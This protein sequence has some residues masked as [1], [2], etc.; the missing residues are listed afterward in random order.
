MSRDS[1]MLAFSG[2]GF[3]LG[4]SVGLVGSAGQLEGFPFL[5]QPFSVGVELGDPY[6]RSDSVLKAL[7]SKTYLNL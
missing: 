6:A 5:L 7:C 1:E 2:L 3:H 4:A